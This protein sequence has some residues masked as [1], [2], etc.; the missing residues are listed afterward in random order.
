MSANLNLKTVF[1]ADTKDLTRGAQQAKKDLKDFGKTSDEVTSSIA[2][3]FGVNTQK[4]EQ[5]SNSTRDLGRRLSESGNTGV[6]AFGKLLQSIDATKTA[7]AGLGF[8][9]AISAFKLLTAEA[10][11]FRNTVQ[12]ARLDIGTNAYLETYSQVLHDFNEETGKGVAE[13]E[14][15]WKEAFGRFK[16]NFSSNV[17]SVLAGKQQ[18][19]SMGEL[20]TSSLLGNTPVEGVARSKGEEAKRLAI[21]INEYQRQIERSS[22]A[23]RESE[24]RVTELRRIAKDDTESLAA[25]S[26]ALAEAHA[27]I[28]Q[29]YNE[30]AALLSKIAENAAKISGLASDSIPAE[31]AMLA[32]NRAVS[33]ILIQKENT[34][35][36]IE[37]EQ[38]TIGKLVSQ[39]A[40]DRAKALADAK[41]YAEAMANARENLEKWAQMHSGSGASQS[42]GSLTGKATTAMEVTA[43]VRPEVDKEATKEAILDL[44]SA[45]SSG[46]AEMSASIGSLIADLVTGENAWKGFAN[47]AISAFADMA[48][49]VGKMS[50]QVGLATEA[51]KTSLETLGG[52]GA[53]A[54]GAALVAL[55]TAAKSGLSNIANG[56]YSASSSIAP[57]SSY[58]T[59][60]TNGGGYATSAIR[61]ELVGKLKAEGRDLVMVLN[62][63]TTRQ[64]VVT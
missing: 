4:L 64:A 30:E 42:S 23:W 55:G 17:V 14:N 7:I 52:W 49:S 11:N 32:S 39:E 21:E 58:G 34:L 37:K 57:A 18:F 31:D 5:L 10:E 28:E 13:F 9:A 59:F 40:A 3:A 20:L 41:A 24:E 15:S 12:G 1:E 36:A 45:L 19:G 63:E 47:G 38:R 29:R 26:N 48:I 8:G 33:D 51:I 22:V 54:A 46:M 27:L 35:K 53:I 43:L 50:I 61:V 25:K 6:A 56:N 44:S 60:G 2:D 62:Q 16:S